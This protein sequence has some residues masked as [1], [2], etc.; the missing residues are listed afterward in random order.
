MNK[1]SFFLKYRNLCS[2]YILHLLLRRKLNISI[3]WM[4]TVAQ[5]SHTRRPINWRKKR[6]AKNSY[7]KH[8]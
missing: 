2:W 3:I 6:Y 8:N 4:A 1:K 7:E 5:I